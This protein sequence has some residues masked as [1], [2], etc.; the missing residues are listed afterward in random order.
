MPPG[1]YADERNCT[2]CGASLQTDFA[3]CPKCGEVLPDRDEV[4]E[5]GVDQELSEFIESANQKLVESG[6]DAAES[7]FG[8][9]CYIGFMPVAIFVILVFAFGV[10]NWIVLALIALGVVLIATAVSTILSRRARSA[11]VKANYYREVQPEME[12]YMHEHNLTHADVDAAALQALSKDA[13]LLKL[14]MFEPTINDLEK[15]K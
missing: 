15:G 6:A 7:A 2:A 11:T 4:A 10:R 3:F 14:L 9:G 5:P 8:L 12:K 1:A 13:P